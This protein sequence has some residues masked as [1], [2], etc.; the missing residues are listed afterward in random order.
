MTGNEQIQM[1]ILSIEFPFHAVNPAYKQQQPLTEAETEWAIG[2]NFE[3]T[4]LNHDWDKV[5][6]MLYL[7]LKKKNAEVI[8]QLSSE[9]IFRVTA[10]LSYRMKYA[11]IAK[12]IDEA[13]GHLIGGWVVKNTNT[14]IA[15][16]V[17][18]PFQRLMDD[19]TAVKKQLYE[20]WE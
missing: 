3:G 15:T 11:A 6:V 2:W 19:E 16:I 10:R 12:I 20:K 17:P 1:G 14:T 18:Q 4:K 5:K 8:A 7:T 9:S 13:L